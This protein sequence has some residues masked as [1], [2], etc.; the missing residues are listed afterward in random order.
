MLRFGIRRFRTLAA[1]L[2]AIP[3]LEENYA[4]Q[5]DLVEKL[6]VAENISKQG[7]SEKAHKLHLSRNK[8]LGM[9]WYPLRTQFSKKYFF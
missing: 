4:K 5:L 9:F 8:V 3:L 2:P 1:Q 7:G 6:S